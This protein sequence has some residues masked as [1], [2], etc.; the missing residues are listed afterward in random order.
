MVNVA[1]VKAFLVLSAD[2]TVDYEAS[3][4][5]FMGEIKGYET[6]VE[7]GDKAIREVVGGLFDQYKGTNI[8]NLGSFVL[9]GLNPTPD[10]IAELTLRVKEWLGAN[11]GERDSGSLLGVKK[12]KGGGSFRHSDKAAD[13]AV[14]TTKA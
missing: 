9:R 10:T 8:T 3:A 11:T 6:L 14:Y 2:G 7:S 5:K 13:D 12:G 1:A 4:H